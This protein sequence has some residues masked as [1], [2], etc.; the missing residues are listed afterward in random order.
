MRESN[1]NR[2]KSGGFRNGVG[3]D[4]KNEVKRMKRVLLDTKIYGKILEEFHQG[5]IRETIERDAIKGALVI[6]GFD[7]IRKELRATSKNARIQ[8]GKLRIALLNLYDILAKKHSIQLNIEM[9]GLAW[10]YYEVYRKLGGTKNE[11]EILND[12]I[13]VAGASIKNLDIVY[14]EDDKTMAGGTSIKSYEIVNNILKFRTPKF[15]S[16]GEFIKEIRRLSS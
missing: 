13:I 6:Y 4:N 8:D 15:E 9:R 16:Y 2:Q 3:F 12:F 1:E 5:I 14:S 10:K 7:V 11:K